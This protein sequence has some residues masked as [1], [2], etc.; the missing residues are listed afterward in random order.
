MESGRFMFGCED[1]NCKFEQRVG[2]CIFEY[3]K[4]SVSLFRNARAQVALAEFGIEPDISD[5]FIKMFVKFS[6]DNK[7]MKIHPAVANSR[8]GDEFVNIFAKYL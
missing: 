8:D 2:R 4:V 7:R 6:S 5:K 3:V 1:Q